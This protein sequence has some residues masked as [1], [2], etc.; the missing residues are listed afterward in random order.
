[1]KK[2]VVLLILMVVLDIAGCQY[3]GTNVKKNVWGRSSFLAVTD[4]QLGLLT[5]PEG[6]FTLFNIKVWVKEIIG[7]ECRFQNYLTV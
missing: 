5:L 1:M 2:A 4:G 6:K 7:V 3:G